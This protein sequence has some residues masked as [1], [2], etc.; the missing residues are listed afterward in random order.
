VTALKEK[1]SEVNSLVRTLRQ[2][3]TSC[4]N[5]KHDIHMSTI[6]LTNGSN[7]KTFRTYRTKT[8][9]TQLMQRIYNVQNRYMCHSQPS[10]Q[11]NTGSSPAKIKRRPVVQLPAQFQVVYHDEMSSDYKAHTHHFDGHFKVQIQLASWPLNFLALSV[12]NLWQADFFCIFRCSQT[13][14]HQ[15]SLD[16]P[17]I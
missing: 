5:N 14:S 3:R 1:N 9:K 4:C 17:S 16:I 10:T 8:A 7:V 6:T 15:V 13:P 2:Q 12:L 11:R